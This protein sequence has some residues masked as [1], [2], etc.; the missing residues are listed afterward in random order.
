VEHADI[1]ANDDALVLKAGRDSDGL[2]VNRPTEDV[3]IRDCIVRH[4]AAAIVSV[5]SSPL[6]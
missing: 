2:R 1:D 6:A 3:V 4:G 5:P